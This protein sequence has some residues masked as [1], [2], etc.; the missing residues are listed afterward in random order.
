MTTTIVAMERGSEW[1]VQIGDLTDVVGLGP[2]DE[3][4]LQRTQGKLDSLQRGKKAVRVAVLACNTATDGEAIG[5]RTTLAHTLLGAVTHSIRGRLILSASDGASDQLRRELFTLAG[6][7]TGELK[8]STTVSLWFTE[9]SHGRAK[10]L[11]ETRTRR[12]LRPQ[13]R[14]DAMRWLA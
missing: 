8:G 10:P 14:E 5:R 13:C 7:L 12:A 1:P 9:P 2:V 11:A 6:E 3:D 4:L